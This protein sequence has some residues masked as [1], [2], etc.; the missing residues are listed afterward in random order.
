MDIQTTLEQLRQERGRIDQAITAIEGLGQSAPRRGRP[1]KAGNAATSNSSGRRTMSA[2]ARAKIA[3]AQRARWAKQKGQ[4]AAKKTST[5]SKRASAQRRMSPA[6]R[7]KLS[8]MMK[9][10]WAARKAKA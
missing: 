3:A 5:A 8:A 10:R 1:P 7:R 9:A 4:P 6:A 2:A